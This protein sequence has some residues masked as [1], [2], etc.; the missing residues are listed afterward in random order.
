MASSSAFVI[1]PIAPRNRSPKIGR[2]GKMIVHARG[3]D[4]H[5]LRKITKIQA[6]VAMGLRSPFGGR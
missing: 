5:L 1:L 3:L 2:A 6:G 4:A